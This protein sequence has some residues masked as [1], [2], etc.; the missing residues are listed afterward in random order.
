MKLIPLMMD[1]VIILGGEELSLHSKDNAVT[2]TICE[3]NTSDY[4]AYTGD[5]VKSSTNQMGGDTPV[6]LFFGVLFHV[7]G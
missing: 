3:V 7:D 6:S 1:L 2:E 4:H 5:T